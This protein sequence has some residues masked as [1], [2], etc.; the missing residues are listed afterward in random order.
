MQLSADDYYDRVFGCWLGKGLAGTVGAPLE[1]RK[2]LF[3]F[4][5]DPRLWARPLPNDDLDLQIVWLE[6]LK[7]H[8]MD[9]TSADLARAFYETCP[10]APGEYGVFKRNFARG[11]LP[12]MS[13]SFNN[14][15]YLNGMGSP[16]RAEIWACVAPGNPRLAAMLAR[17]DAVLDHAGDSVYAEQFIA[18]LEAAAFHESN[19]KKL[20]VDALPWL[21]VGS[22]LR[23]L[24]E[25]VVAWCAEPGARWEDVRVS[26]LR[27]FGHADCTNL[28]QNIGITLLALWFG[29]QDLVRT[30]MIALNCGYDTDCT[31]AT[32]G[33]ILGIIGGARQLK[34][35]HGIT[36]TGYILGVKLKPADTSFAAL[37]RDVCEVGRK[38]FAG[39]SAD[40]LHEEATQPDSCA[41]SPFN[42]A[43]AFEVDYGDHP[44]IHPGVTKFLKVRLKFRDP[45]QA[46][47]QAS[48]AGPT[49]WKCAINQEG[50]TRHGSLAVFSLAVTVPADVPELPE[51]N[52][53]RLTWTAAG[54]STTFSFGLV[55]AALVRVYGPF[56]ENH[57]KALQPDL[58]ETYRM[59]TAETNPDLKEDILREYHISSRA[60]LDKAYIPEPG[61]PRAQADT[62]RNGRSDPT[63]FVRKSLTEDLFKV[64]DLVGYQGPCVVYLEREIV[65]HEARNCYLYLGYSDAFKLWLN[66]E[67]IAMAD[68]VAWW[69]AENRHIAV[70]LR[71]G[72]NRLLLKCARRSQEA[73][74]SLVFANGRSMCDQVFDLVSVR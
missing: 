10:Y 26:I 66:D 11:V 3:D 46:T 64:G 55:G 61:A 24:V 31:C 38:Y 13:G 48:V 70:R 44:A 23:A 50:I 17:R 4:Q 18:A 30:T 19:L 52:E 8:G 49:G 62:I 1:G 41:V 58:A 51:K 39:K 56:I 45:A 60:D 42:P 67:P 15:Y 9:F 72:K 68:H 27:D 47:G 32:S 35:R 69:T 16:I 65:S 34:A 7:Q 25:A 71:Q 63:R 14:R 59:E 6:V 22:K 37:A 53:L 21:P 36:D 20:I 57:G 54:A 73:Q 29:E 43:V 12:P 33:A 28:Y 74:Y 40:A 2:E 5:F